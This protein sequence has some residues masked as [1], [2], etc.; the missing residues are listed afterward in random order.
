MQFCGE[1]NCGVLVSSGKCAAHA[2][3]VRLVQL[4]YRQVHRWYCST[5]WQRLR[6][7]VLTDGPFCRACRDRGVKALA[8]D[9]DH[10]RKHD[11]VPEIFWERANLQ[12]LCKRCH[13]VKTSRGE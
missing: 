13:T 9:V 4:D 2:P 7:A 1:P 12:G 11:G 10:I 8:V 6:A 3:R 5:R